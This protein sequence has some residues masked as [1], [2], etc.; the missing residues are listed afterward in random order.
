MLFGFDDLPS[1]EG[2]LLNDITGHVLH[3]R[4]TPTGGT[5]DMYT[6]EEWSKRKEYF[7]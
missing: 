1:K 6:Y 3:R 2:L 5:V 4:K 7:F